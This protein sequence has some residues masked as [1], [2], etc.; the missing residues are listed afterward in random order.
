[1]K[2]KMK[3]LTL[4]ILAL[5]IVGQTTNAFAV[6]MFRFKGLGANASFSSM[7]ASG[8]IR[9]NVDVFTAEAMLHSPPG[10]KGPFTSVDLYFSQYN[11][12][13]ETALIAAEGIADLADPDLQ[14]DAKLNSAS[15]H[16]TLTMLD[17]LTGQPFDLYV[18]LTWTATVPATR[19]HPNI[20]Y[21]DKDCKVL[22]HGTA[23]LQAADATGT[24][25]DGFTNFTPDP[26]VG[27]LLVSS[28][29]SDMSIRCDG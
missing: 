25:S 14:I 7:D 21:G 20:H 29:S 23:I 3:Y 27:A 5:A 19:E 13:T 15:L 22:N 28:N 8:C 6:S 16:T 11:L 18:D 26:S 4:M 2:T 17:S 10:Q 9:T 12:C 1:M 24:V